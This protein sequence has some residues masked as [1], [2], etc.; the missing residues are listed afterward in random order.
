MATVR[1][2]RRGT[3]GRWR[4]EAGQTLVET[5]LSISVLLAVLFGVLETSMLVYTYHFISD[6]A[7][8]GTRYAM[9]RGSTFTTDCTAPGL[10][11]CIA[12]GGNNTGD[13]ATYIKG[14]GFPGISNSNIT[15]NS[16]WLSSAGA[17]CGAADTCKAPGNIAKITVTYNFP[18]SVPFVPK[19]TF[20]MSSTS[21]MVVAQ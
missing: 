6:A 18:F 17:A 21:Q 14:L 13:I 4:G 1:A 16:T 3:C 7:R 12:Q 9:V 15:V 2:G 19:E 8:E 10:A 11:N 20:S 5:A